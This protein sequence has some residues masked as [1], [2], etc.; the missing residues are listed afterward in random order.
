[1]SFLSAARKTDEPEPCDADP[2]PTDRFIFQVLWPGRQSNTD[3][4]SI[5]PAL[6][7][8]ETKDK[9]ANKCP[10]TKNIFDP[11]FAT[12]LLRMVEIKVRR[13]ENSQLARET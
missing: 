2:D 10:H 11:K 7:K 12:R 8:T 5:T 1:L 4:P 9:T 6:I 3:Q 13:D